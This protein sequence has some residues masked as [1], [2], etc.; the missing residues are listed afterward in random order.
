MRRENMLKKVKKVKDK[1]NLKKTD[2]ED[3]R[4]SDTG[5]K[6]KTEKDKLDKESEEKK[7]NIERRIM[8]RKL[9]PRKKKR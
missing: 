1:E 4:I 2:Y 9:L 5:K 6:E 8:E 3:M 7:K